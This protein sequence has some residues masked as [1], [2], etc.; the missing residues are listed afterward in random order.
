MLVAY[1]K[2]CDILWRD[3]PLRT[4]GF[5]GGETEE[6]PVYPTKHFKDDTE[7]LGAEIHRDTIRD[8][9]ETLGMVGR[10]SPLDRSL[11]NLRVEFNGF[12][13]EVDEAFKQNNDLICR[14]RDEL[15]ALNKDS[16]RETGNA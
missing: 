3:D 4:C 11:V 16:E 6:R 2:K 10:G 9:K 12:R 13:D 8:W 1:C 15:K 5:C 14:L 7:P